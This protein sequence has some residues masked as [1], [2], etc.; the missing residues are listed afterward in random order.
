MDTLDTVWDSVESKFAFN[1]NISKTINKE[2]V[3][4]KDNKKKNDAAKKAPPKKQD[5]KAAKSADKNT[6]KSGPIT[7]E[8]SNIFMKLVQYL[9]D[10]RA[11][12][13]RVTWPARE[14]VIYLV[15]VVVVTLLFFATYTA[16]VDW[17]SSEGVVALNNLTH[18]GS[19]ATGGAEVPVEIDWG[20]L[21]LDGGVVEEGV[22]DSDSGVTIETN[23]EPL[24]TDPPTEETEE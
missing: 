14:K 17:G 23:I 7:E 3:M 2:A 12:L 21:D 18:D 9:I 8:K 6:K 5:A 24:D 10:V 16:L 4:A 13:K 11:E 19:T 20:D 22:I 15:G 1:S